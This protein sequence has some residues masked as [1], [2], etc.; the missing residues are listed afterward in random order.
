VPP[1]SHEVGDEF[2]GSANF[3]EGDDIGLGIGQPFIHALAG[4]GPQAVDVDSCDFQHP[5]I[6][7]RSKFRRGRVAR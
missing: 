6:V 7:P 2:V 3:L 1:L 4:R 5:S